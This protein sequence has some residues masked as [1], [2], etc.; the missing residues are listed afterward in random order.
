M[1]IYIRITDTS[2]ATLRSAGLL[3]C[4]SA[5]LESVSEPA[6]LVCQGCLITSLRA[7]SEGIATLVRSA[8]TFILLAYVLPSDMSL[9]DFGLAQVSVYTTG[10]S[11]SLSLALCTDFLMQRFPHPAHPFYVGELFID[12]VGSLLG[13]CNL[14][15]K[16]RCKRKQ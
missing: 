5:A 3:F 9:L 11:V 6:Y 2:D 13:L 7:Y 8:L 15:R 14:H 10:A 1:H 16:T 4:L 12:P